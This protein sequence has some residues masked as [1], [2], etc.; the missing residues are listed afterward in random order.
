MK[1][2]VGD[3]GSFTKT[4]TEHDVY[5][6][7]GITGDFNSAHVN[8]V[9]AKKTQF[10]KRIAH[11]MLS[12]GLISTVLGMYMPGPGTIYLEQELHFTAPVFYNDTITAKVEI[13]EIIKDKIGKLKTTC[14][15]QNGQEVINGHATVLLPKED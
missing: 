3:C 14:V 8:E 4:I 13:I 9:D 15:N 1:F 12:A 2:K 5:T 10:K 11:G 6:F 7:A